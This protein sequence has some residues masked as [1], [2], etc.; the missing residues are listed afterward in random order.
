MIDFNQFEWLSFDCY[1][2]LID[3]EI[4][5][6]DAVSAV[7]ESHDIHL[8]RSE[9]LELFA[10]VE[11]QI[12][13]GGRFLE[14][15]RVLRRVMALIGIKMDFRFTE[16][17]MDCLVE[18][19]P[20]WPVFP[21]TQPALR[22]LKTRYKLAVISNVDDDLFAQTAGVLGVEFDTVVTAQQVRSYKPDHRN[23]LT[24]LERMDVDRDRWL[25]VAESLYHDIAPANALGIASVWV[26]RGHARDG[27]GATPQSGARPDLEVQDL[28]ALVEL[29]GT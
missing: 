12:Q 2:T 19:L 4:G 16:S 18:S 23:F 22:A 26:N 28:A 9:V 6:S 10:E 17:D 14:Y 20:R 11:P 5:I 13:H 29:M 3:W 25:H 27:A 7:L 1:G 24:A 8:S 15:R 21:D